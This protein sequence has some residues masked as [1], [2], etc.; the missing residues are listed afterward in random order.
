MYWERRIMTTENARKHR[1]LKVEL[2]S[3]HCQ[4]HSLEFENVDDAFSL[5]KSQD[6]SGLA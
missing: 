1:R 2:P 3:V 6:E 4:A 5:F